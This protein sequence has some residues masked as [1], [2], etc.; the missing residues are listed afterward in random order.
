[1]KVVQVLNGAVTF[2]CLWIGSRPARQSARRHWLPDVLIILF[3]F[4]G[5]E[6]PT[7]TLWKGIRKY[8]AWIGPLGSLNLKD[9]GILNHLKNGNFYSPYIVVLKYKWNE[10]I[11][12][13]RFAQ[14]SRCSFWNHIKLWD[15]HHGHQLWEHFFFKEMK[16]SYHFK[17][18]KKLWEHFVFKERRLSYHL[19]ITKSIPI[20]PFSVYQDF[21]VFPLLCW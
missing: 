17:I 7:L 5:F 16:S 13:I 19:K 11:W 12:F 10:S 4:Q 6:K 15:G 20:V 9:K 8:S 21:N 18:P 3:W 1:M 14:F 2:H